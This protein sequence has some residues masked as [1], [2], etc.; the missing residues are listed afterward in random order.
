MKNRNYLLTIQERY[1]IKSNPGLSILL[2]L[3]YGFI[4][5]SVHT[6]RLVWPWFVVIGGPTQVNEADDVKGP[7]C[8]FDVKAFCSIPFSILKL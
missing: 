8:D 3:N 7:K 1:I 6:E 5:V 4:L 2:V